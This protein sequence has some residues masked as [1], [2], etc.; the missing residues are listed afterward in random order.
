MPNI[1]SAFTG[2][3]ATGV[4]GSGSDGSATLDGVATVPWASK[5]GSVYTLTRDVNAASLTVNAGS[6]IQTVNFRILATGT[7]TNNGTITNPPG[8]ASGSSAGLFPSGSTSFPAGR[9]GGAGG[10]GA[11]GAGGNGVSGPIGATG[12][13]GGAGTSGTAGTGGGATLPSAALAVNAALQMPFAMLIGQLAYAFNLQAIGAGGSG[14]GG[15]AD[16]G[17]VAGGGGGSSGGV[18]A[19]CAAALVNN[20]TITAP[21]GN[22]AAGTGGNAGGGGGG[23]GGIILIYTLAPV[24]GAGTITAAAGA[25]GAGSGTGSAGTP[26]A[27]GLVVTS[28]L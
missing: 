24:T 3:T 25:Q 8:N 2:L 7:V 17:A 1:P 9:A 26:G 12:G 18:I 4:F 11:N 20:G 28:V 16:A 23:T 21:G 5:A 14:G 19:I 10:T 22:G 15:G 13:P 6:T 27:A